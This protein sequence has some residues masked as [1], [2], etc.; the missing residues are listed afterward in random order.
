MGRS[1]SC[2]PVEARAVLRSI[3]P[4]FN[5]HSQQDAQELLLFLL[6]ALHDDLK[7]V[8]PGLNQSTYRDPV[9]VFKVS[10]RQTRSS[11]PQLR[12][13][14]GGNGAAKSSTVVSHL[15]EGQLSYTT[16]CR[17]CGHQSYST[18]PFTVLSL[19]IPTDTLKCSIQVPFHSCRGTSTDI[20][21]RCPALASV[22]HA[23]P[24]LCCSGL[25]VRVL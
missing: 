17:Q 22:A 23:V 25:S 18:Q 5:N 1:S 4:Q 6:N 7:K 21:A 9:R 8:Q 12:R 10:Q 24:S 16:L 19:P 3:L 14:P 13:D 15:F 20:R 2:A 11:I